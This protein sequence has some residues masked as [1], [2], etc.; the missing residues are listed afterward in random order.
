MSRLI[1]RLAAT[2]AS[3]TIKKAIAHKKKLLAA[4]K[5]KKFDP[6]KDPAIKAA[7]DKA[8]KNIKETR[9]MKKDLKRGK[10]VLKKAKKITSAAKKKKY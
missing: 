5:K 10:K 6:K 3:K 1:S 8:A 2:M 7:R 9:T 4:K